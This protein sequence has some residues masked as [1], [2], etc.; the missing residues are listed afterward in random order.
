[1]GTCTDRRLSAKNLW[2][3]L[4][5][6]PF[7]QVWLDFLLAELAANV[8]EPLVRIRIV[9]RESALV[10]IRLAERDLL[11]ERVVNSH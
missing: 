2:V 1:M 10:P 11:A 7:I 9:R 8:S 3:L 4:L 6:D 5:R